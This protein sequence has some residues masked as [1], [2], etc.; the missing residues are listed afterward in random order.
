MHNT[1]LWLLA[2]DTYMHVQYQYRIEYR[3]LMSYLLELAG[4]ILQASS[5]L[6]PAAQTM[7]K[8]CEH[9]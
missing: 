3:T 1:Q 6:F 8:P 9:I 4:D 2:L 5:L 7:C